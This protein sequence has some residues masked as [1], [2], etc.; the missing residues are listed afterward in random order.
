MIMIMTEN[1][2]VR[3]KEIK[4]K[5][6]L[7]AERAKRNDDEIKLVAVSKTHPSEILRE[8]LETGI[9]IFGE[10]KVQEAE[11]KILETGQEKAKWH[12]IGHLQSNKVRKAAKLFDVIHTIDSVELARRLER[13]CK[14]EGRPVLSVLIQVDLGGEQ[15]K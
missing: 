9:N 14:E 3:F 6:K 8:A 15:T 7:A 2:E 5:I 10:N 12:L 4:N 13:I 1:L 11:D